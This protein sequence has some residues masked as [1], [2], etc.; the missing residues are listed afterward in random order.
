LFNYERIKYK[1]RTLIKLEIEKIEIF[2]HVS[3]LNQNLRFLK[4]ST[5]VVFNIK[6]SK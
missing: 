1:I 3:F 5:K 2:N 4:V 6:V